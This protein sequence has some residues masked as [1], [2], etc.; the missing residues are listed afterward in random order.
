[1]DE[2][3]MD[4]QSKIQQ[5]RIKLEAR[6]KSEAM[7][8]LVLGS[9][10]LVFCFIFTLGGDGYVLAVILGIVGCVFAGESKKA[11]NTSAVRKLGL[12]LSWIGI[13]FGIISFILAVINNLEVQSL[14]DTTLDGIY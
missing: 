4:E 1:M 6:G 5:I 8:A 12:I 11:G 2:H 10:S 9:L 13:I 7:I 3:N 14:L